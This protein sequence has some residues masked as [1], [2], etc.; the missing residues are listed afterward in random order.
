MSEESYETKPHPDRLENWP[1]FQLFNDEIDGRI[2]ACKVDSWQSYIDNINKEK[3]D[4]TG[5]EKIYRGQRRFDWALES[6]LSREVNGGAISN[7]ISQ[8][9]L[10]RFKLAMRGRGVDLSGWEEKE[11]WAYGQHYGLATP[12][13]DW[14]E[15]PFVALLFAFAQEEFGSEIGNPTRAIFCINRDAI[16]EALGEEFLF[17][18][19]YGDNGRLVN[20]AG[21]FIVTPTGDENLASA[22]I[23]ALA[24]AGAVNPDDANDLA[25][26]ISKIHV[27]DKDRLACLTMLRKMNIHHANLFPDPVGASLFCNDWLRRYFEEGE[28]KKAEKQKAE[29]KP[30][31]APAVQISD[32][33]K[34][35]AADAVNVITILMEGASTGI[36]AGRVKEWSEKVLNAYSESASLDWTISDSGRA[37]VKVAFRRL[38]KILEYPEDYHFDVVSKLTEYFATKYAAP[39]AKTK[40]PS[41]LFF[42]TADK[43]KIDD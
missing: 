12:L 36:E 10:Q 13:L 21:L 14:T 7:D 27:P 42:V 34:S 11:I 8:R 31:T 17:E 18:P 43:K 23:N 26:Y 2:P 41:Q 30:K 5:R 29:Q 16:E 40:T 33:I 25:Q 6:S 28:K 37:K 3:E 4:P 32:L 1:S 38:L 19:A 20:Q 24:K 39:E 22:I 15:S 9:L 35:D